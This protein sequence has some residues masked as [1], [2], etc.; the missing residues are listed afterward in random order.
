[1]KQAAVA[2]TKTTHGQGATKKHTYQPVSVEK[3]PTARKAAR[4]VKLGHVGPPVRHTFPVND[5]QYAWQR[6]S[7]TNPLA[8]KLGYQDHKLVDMHTGKVVGTFTDT[9]GSWPSRNK[10]FGDFTFHNEVVSKDQQ[11]GAMMAMMGL[12]RGGSAGRLPAVRLI[13]QQRPAYQD[14]TRARVVLVSNEMG[15]LIC[16]RSSNAP[17]STSCD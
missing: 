11:T 16:H 17:R 8:T 5:K 1:M 3:Y 12:V 6:T 2:K 9:R 10:Q 13:Q 4:A 7:E 15:R 14:R